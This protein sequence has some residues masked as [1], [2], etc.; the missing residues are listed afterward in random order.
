MRYCLVFFLFTFITPAGHAQ[1]YVQIYNT[2]KTGINS[3][4]AI[5][6]N[7]NK[8]LSWVDFKG[9]PD[10]PE[11]TAA[12]T[13]S[14]FGYKAAMKSVDG[15]EEINIGIYCYFNKKKSW[16]RKGRN[17]PYILNHEQHHFDATYIASKMFIKKLMESNI[18]A[19]NMNTLLSVVYKESI[20]SLNKMQ[21]DYDFQSKNGRDQIKQAEWDKFFIE[22]LA[23]F[24]N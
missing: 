18:T 24:T 19:E 17:T 16:V 9:I 20:A 22:K 2:E 8:K 7:K 21:N 12:I 3:K 5:Y 10:M 23:E 6:F 14:G 13:S 15:K 4:E 11:P 1:A